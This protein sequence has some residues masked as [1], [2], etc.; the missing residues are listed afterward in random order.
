MRAAIYARFSSDKQQERSIDDQVAL[1]R[2]ICDRDG[3]TVIRV[4][5]DRALSG[6]STINRLGLQRLLRDA[7]E[8]QFDVVVTEALDRLSRDQEDLAGMFKRLRFAGISI[9]TAQDGI[10]TDI[11]VGV[12]GLLGQMYLRDLAQ[13]VHRGQAGVLRDGRHNGGHSYGYQPV[14]GRPGELTIDEQ[15]AAVVRAIFRDYV[16]GLSPRDIATS[17]N[18]RSVP[19]P[20]GGV[21]NASTITGSR[22]RAN[23][24]LRNELYAGKIV[25]NRQRFIKDPDTGRRVSRPNP[26]DQWMTADAVHLRIIDSET[27][28]RASARSSMRGSQQQRRLATRPQNLLSGLI[29]C[30]CCGSGFVVNGVGRA[31]KV[32][33][34]SRMR[35]TGL[36][37]NRLSIP[38]QEIEDRTLRAI[39]RD[40]ADPVLIAE[41]VREYHR[42]RNEMARDSAGRRKLA[43]AKLRTVLSAIEKTVDAIV[44]VGASRALQERLAAQEAERDAIEQELATM[45]TPPISFHPR[46]A[47]ELAERVGDLKAMLAAADQENRDRATAAI[48]QMVEKIVVF[49]PADSKMPANLEVH[50]HLATLLCLSDPAAEAA[51]SAGVLVAGTRNSHPHTLPALV[52]TA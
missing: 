46:A 36:C 25:W 40:L 49:P 26:P 8:G 35:E 10:A 28:A 50:G 17:L 31:G 1:C 14:P 29:K 11:H 16:G 23:G 45:T 4:Y 18:Q 2:A 6:A 44:A 38:L 13:K 22:T 43:E 39:E 9:L 27:W 34:C 51:G 21:W 32:L 20:R 47:A 7:R 52:L 24:I 42:A 19:G 15:E 33:R 3:L 48:R 12:K 30:G 37:D 5:D 41:Y